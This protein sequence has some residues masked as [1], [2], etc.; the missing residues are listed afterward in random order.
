MVTYQP[1]AFCVK[2]Q[3]HFGGDVHEVAVPAHNGTEP[4]VGDLM[5]LIEHDLRIPRT[6]Q[7]LIYHGRELHSHSQEPLSRFGIKNLSVIRLVGR[8]APAELIPQINAYYQPTTIH[9]TT[10][11]V[12]QPK[13]TIGTQYD[14]PVEEQ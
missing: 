11:V 14:P 5:T 12:C 13:I 8:M 3:L 9:S 7:H 1:R 10:T 2:L 6:L 4:T